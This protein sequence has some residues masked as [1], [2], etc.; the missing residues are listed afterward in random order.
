[1]IIKVIGTLNEFSNTSGEL[2]ILTAC[3][4]KPKITCFLFRP[5]K[6]KPSL[7]AFSIHASGQRCAPFQLPFRACEC[8]SMNVTMNR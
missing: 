4:T 6:I 5:T 7:Y 1:M 3:I 2:K 8:L